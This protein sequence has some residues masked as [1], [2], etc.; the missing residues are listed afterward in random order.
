LYLHVRLTII[1][2]PFRMPTSPNW[3]LLLENF[4]RYGTKVC[5]TAVG[6]ERGKL[7]LEIPSKE[8]G[9]TSQETRA[10]QPIIVRES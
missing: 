4:P 10:P 8:P 6:W 3:E 1:E 9:A 5:Y 7:R 2:M